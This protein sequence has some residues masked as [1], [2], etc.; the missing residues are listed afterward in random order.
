[1]KKNVIALLLAVVMAS[2]SI[3]SVPG[4]AAET[5]LEASAV[6][7]ESVEEAAEEISGITEGVEEFSAETEDIGE[8]SE[9]SLDEADDE[10]SENTYEEV[11]SEEQE[12]A[13]SK[14][15]TGSASEESADETEAELSNPA[16]IPETNEQEEALENED[17]DEDVKTNEVQ[18]ADESQD[19][20]SEGVIVEEQE[21][22]LE[23]QQEE[24]QEPGLAAVYSGDSSSAYTNLVPVSIDITYGQTEARSMLNEINYFRT[25]NDAWAWNEDNTSKYQYEGLNELEYDS[26]LEEVAMKRAAEIALSY[27]HVRPDGTDAAYL[28]NG[29][30][31]PF[32]AFGENIAAGYDSYGEAF[33]AWLEEDEDYS[34][35]GHRRNMLT[36][37][38]KSVGI[39]HAEYQGV[40]FWVQIFCDQRFP[41]YDRSAYD[42]NREVEVNVCPDR[43]DVQMEAQPETL[44]IPYCQSV[45]LPGLEIY[46]RDEDCWNN[47]FCRV[48]TN[49]DWKSETSGIELVSLGHHIEENG[50]DHLVREGYVHAA[51]RDTPAYL[52]GNISVTVLDN[53]LYVPV[54]I[55]YSIPDYASVTFDNTIEVYDGTEKKPGVTVRYG[56]LILTEGRDYSLTYSNCISPGTAT[57]TIRGEGQ[58]A[59]ERS[60]QYLIID[61]DAEIIE[62]G[63]IEFHIRWMFDSQ[64]TLLLTGSDE[65]Y[66]TA[67]DEV[68]WEKY[69]D[70]IKK[71][72]IGEGI[73]SISPGAFAFCINLEE[74]VLPS[75]LVEISSE[76]FKRCEKLKTLVIPDSVTETGIWCFVACGLESVTLSSSMQYVGTGMFEECKNLKTVVFSDNLEGI[77]DNAFSG[78]ENLTSITLPESVTYIGGGAFENCKNLKEINIPTSVSYLGTGAFADCESLEKIELPDTL[79]EIYYE[80]FWNCT[81]L[82]EVKFP[83]NLQ[84]IETDA[85]FNTKIREVVLPESVTDIGAIPTQVGFSGTIGA[86]FMGCSE[87]EYV[88]LPKELKLIRNKTFYGCQN[89]KRIELPE[90]LEEIESG[91]FAYC[92]SLQSI[93]LPDSLTKIGQ[94]AFQRDISLTDITIPKGVSVINASTFCDCKSLK[95]IPFTHSVE[96]IGFQAFCACDSLTD[97]TIPEGITVIGE[98]AFM[99]CESLRSVVI[100]AGC[101]QIEGYAFWTCEAL[102]SLTIGEGL[103][104]IGAIALDCSHLYDIYLPASIE[105]IGYDAFGFGK[106]TIHYDGTKNQWNAIDNSA[107]D[108]DYIA[109]YTIRC[110]DGDILFTTPDETPN[111]TPNVTPNEK[112]DQSITA[113][114]SV[115]ALPVGRTTT[116][117]VT[118]NK[119]ILSFKSG[120]TSIATVNQTTGVISAKK[121]GTVNITVT[122]A[123]TGDY[124]PV[125]K[126]MTIK[127]VPAATSSVTAVNLATGIKLTWKKVAGAN[128]YII[129]RN[130]SKIKTITSGST[131]TYTDKKANTNGTKYTYKVVAK[132]TTGTSTLSR[133]LTTYRVARNA[134]SSLASRA[135]GKMT[136]KWKRN[137]KAK[138]YQVQYSKSKS[139]SS[140]NKTLTITKNTLINKTIGSLTKGKKYYVRV[141]SFKTVSG[142]KYYS[143]WSAVKVVTVKK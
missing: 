63:S 6:E 30:G 42:G 40:H 140:G 61:N 69:K 4:F 96:S 45:E 142:K 134:I 120:N 19:S 93:S 87:L 37:V 130:G 47:E 141:R 14:D 110:K 3:G 71:V 137:S 117:T 95:D 20:L 139:F 7:T 105:T 91:A 16:H 84:T 75:T 2:S 74:L 124:K 132:A 123:G 68:P 66:L 13:S 43:V 135:A 52:T 126:T 109:G 90:G 59:G 24:Q 31:V 34:G 38:F 85:F 92:E 9:Q 99:G 60:E 51:D 115:S 54:V 55:G 143:A 112:K 22:Q 100:P 57:V 10:E 73:T 23:E 53:T 128:G 78:C 41:S 111:G 101:D 39:G 12:E 98:Q 79:T 116:I 65:M 127:V 102:E 67:D 48:Y 17:S 125:S 18:S 131:V 49:Y 86:A 70:K 122:A 5:T 56:D 103:R 58:Y 89:L 118:G 82:E 44:R 29:Y 104:S 64:G 21:E 76:A 25:G 106:K 62:S 129:Y 50:F 80:T 1:M 36:S 26:L 114:V 107:M 8:S 81:S 88:K 32:D 108:P 15:A 46:I 77:S 83:S 33:E 113:N 121:V 27:S 28:L 138:G 94:A 97:I 133:S 35:Q 119:G 72:I 136:V 11:L